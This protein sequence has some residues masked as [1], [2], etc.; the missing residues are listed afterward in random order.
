MGVSVKDVAPQEFNKAL[1]AFLKKSGKMKVPDWIDIVKTAR[2]KELAP[3]DEDWF[4]NRAASVCRHLYIRAPVGVGAL[5]KIYGGKMSNGTCPSHYCRASP[6]VSRR[7]LQAL[8]GLKLV[9]K[10]P[11][12][13]GRKLTSQGR[14]D[15][16]RIAS[17]IKRPAGSA[18]AAKK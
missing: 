11:N 15:L 9:E 16:D 6:T 7:V 12:T 8:E 17:Q 3:Y 14:R 18:P 10:D 13:G 4:Y 1:A 2:Y 5:G